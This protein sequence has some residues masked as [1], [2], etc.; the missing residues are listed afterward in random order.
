MPW[1]KSL[2]EEQSAADKTLGPIPGLALVD[3]NGNPLGRCHSE[4]LN[5]GLDDSRFCVLRGWSDRQ[6]VYLNLPTLMAAN[7]SPFTNLQRLRLWNL[8]ARVVW[9]FFTDQL[10]KRVP[11]TLATGIVLKSYADRLEALANSAIN[12][13]IIVPGKVQDAKVSVLRTDD[14]RVANPKLS[15]SGG[16]QCFAYDTYIDLNLGFLLPG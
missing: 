13:A 7:G 14:Q 11:Y 6:G 15:V 8:F 4:E 5:P 12:T 10:Q 1:I 9:T 3:G 16:I 2:A